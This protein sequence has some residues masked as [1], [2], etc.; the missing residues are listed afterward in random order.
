MNFGNIVQDP[1]FSRIIFEIEKRI[2]AW[3]EESQLS[4]ISW[5]DSD[6]KSALRKVMGLAK[7]AHP[8]LPEKNKKEKVFK[9]LVLELS[10]LG[11]NLQALESDRPV[12]N[13]DWIVSLK[14]VEDSLKTR[15]E[16]YGHSRGYLEFLD[17]FLNEGKI[18]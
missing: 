3:D 1:H 13:K 18:M 6:V 12:S 7:G 2:Y 15:R 16:M 14:A 11:S 8:S 5:K 10:E 9:K 17:G 4:E